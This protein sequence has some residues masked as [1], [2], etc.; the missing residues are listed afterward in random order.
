MKDESTQAGQRLS[1]PSAFILRGASLA[2][3]R[4]GLVLVELVVK[5]LERDP[6]FQ[7]GFRLVPAVLVEHVMN[8]V[9][10]DFAK[11]LGMTAG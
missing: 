4:I 5:R 2:G 9:H 6:E 3:G 11:C 8:H 7:G 1:Q 10:F